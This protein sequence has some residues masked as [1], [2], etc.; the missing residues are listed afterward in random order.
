MGG[1]DWLL[2]ISLIALLALTLVHAVRLERAL[3][4]LRRDRTALG[5]AVAGFDS[6]AREA[7]SGLGRL[8]VMTQEATQQATRSIEGAA[9]LK[10]DLAFLAKRGEEL[11]DRLEQL[12]RAGRALDPAR[13]REQP[14]AAAPV[15]AA[16]ARAEPAKP[17]SD[18]R[19]QSD[20]RE[21][22][23]S[24]PRS[25]SERDLQA[26]PDGGTLM[27]ALPRLRRPQ[28]PRVL[29]LAI[30]AMGGLLVA[31]NRAP[32][33]KPPVR[34]PGG[35][36]QRRARPCCP[37]PRPPQATRRPLK[38][39]PRKHLSSWGRPKKR[40]PR[41]HRARTRRPPRRSQRPQRRPRRS[42]P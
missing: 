7:E 29:P 19:E 25:K 36:R 21:A 20:L 2:E 12:I 34:R 10:D 40:Q 6:S 5:E 11:A 42:R 9:V 27:R 24:R 39:Q 30:L 15:P 41:R 33:S 35:A 32:R 1:M 3:G 22:A 4:L 18:L 37:A 38:H 26:S 31:E 14:A 23:P 28:R 16:P 13:A 8:R 17:P